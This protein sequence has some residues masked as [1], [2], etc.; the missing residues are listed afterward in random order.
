MREKHIFY[1]KFCII[2]AGF[3]HAILASFWGFIIKAWFL[4]DFYLLPEESYRAHF[5]H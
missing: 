2:L 4:Q 5:L 3:Q 1:Y